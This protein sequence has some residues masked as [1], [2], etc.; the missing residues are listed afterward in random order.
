MIFRL[1]S[2]EKVLQ[3]RIFSLWRRDPVLELQFALPLRV[4]LLRFAVSVDRRG[5]AASRFLAAAAACVICVATV[6]NSIVP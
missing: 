2:L 1:I 6:H 4:L 3:N 5:M